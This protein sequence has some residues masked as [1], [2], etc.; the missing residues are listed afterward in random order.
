MGAFGRQ[1]ERHW[2]K[3]PGF[4]PLRRAWSSRAS[5]L[6]CSSVFL[7]SSTSVRSCVFIGRSKPWARRPASLVS[8]PPCASFS[9]RIW[10][11]ISSICAR[12]GDSCRWYQAGSFSGGSDAAAC[13]SW[14][15]FWEVLGDFEGPP[16]TDTRLFRELRSSSV[17]TFFGLADFAGAGFP[18]EFCWAAGWAELSGGCAGEEDWPRASAR[19]VAAKQT[20]K[21][22]DE[23][24]PRLISL[25][26]FSISGAPS[27]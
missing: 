9:F 25:P 27:A 13:L 24:T 18:E 11:S 22:A 19:K 15:G 26:A 14:G 21:M 6:A 1:S 4:N 10:A 2:R 23:R 17:Q 3:S 20:A 7:F 16:T 12:S 8:L 5:T